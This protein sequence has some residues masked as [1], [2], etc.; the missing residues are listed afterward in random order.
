M[1]IY[2]KIQHFYISHP[3]IG[4][5]VGPGDL[6]AFLR[7]Y[8]LKFYKILSLDNVPDLLTKL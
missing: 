1:H 5:F 6:P 7:K 4:S 2:K 8:A 3:I